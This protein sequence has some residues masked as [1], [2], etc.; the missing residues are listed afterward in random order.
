MATKAVYDQCVMNNRNKGRCDYYTG[1]YKPDMK[2][3]FGKKCLVTKF[4]FLQLGKV[5]QRRH[6]SED[7]VLITLYL[8]M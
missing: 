4:E 7:R 2:F 1:S 3:L 5:E 6:L 8:E